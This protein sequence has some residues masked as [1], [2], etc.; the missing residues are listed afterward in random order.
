MTDLDQ[1]DAPPIRIL[2]LCGSLR[3]GSYT[4]HALR[5][6]AAAATAAGA[7]VTTLDL[8]E[9]PLPFCDG[10][11]D[12]DSYPESARRLREL[13]AE[14]DALL[15]ATP[16][17]HN[18]FSGVMKNAL[19]LL[20]FDQLAGKVCALIS[21]AGGGSAMSSLS[22]LRIVLRAVHAWV[23]PQQVMIPS[24]WQAIADGEVADPK[25]A[26]R[27]EELGRELVAKARVLRGARA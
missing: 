12:F 10:R 18:S 4:Q 6:A 13:A 7:L 1:A 27:L 16:E 22:H 9:Q 5:R 15:L 23:L 11:K 26:A 14:A 20:S 25:L 19:D 21:I 24:A 8:G 2:A 3:E 17:Y